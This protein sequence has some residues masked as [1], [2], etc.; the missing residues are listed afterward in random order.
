MKLK[1]LIDK[2]FDKGNVCVVGLRGRGKDMLF[3]NVI[4]RR[5]SPYISNTDY[6]CD[7]Q[8]GTL[9]H[10]FRGIKSRSN[11]YIP[12]ELN[13]LDIKNNYKNFI[14]GDIVKYDYPYPQKADIY[15]ADCGVYLPS[16][17]CNIL[18]RDYDSFPEFYALSR[19]IAQCN[20]HFNVQNLNRVW[21]KLRE[22][23]DFYI[24][25]DYCKVLIG[26]FVVQ[27]VTIYDK[28]QSCVDR[29]KPFK[30]LPKPLLGNSESRAMYNTKNL[31]L[32]RNFDEKN[33]MVK[34]RFL[35]YKNRSK[36]DT[37]LFGSILKKGGK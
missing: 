12:L 19:Q 8:R 10:P 21:D 15:I 24:Q 35:I 36:Y 3:A 11:I 13:A 22:Q 29:V 2:Y 25:C 18:N 31:E 17:Y 30:P 37:R 16:Q 5:Y 6:Q 20:V 9:F 34:S 33:G 32:K 27:K 14:N 1:K 4:A 23:S 7:N 26:K 28:Y